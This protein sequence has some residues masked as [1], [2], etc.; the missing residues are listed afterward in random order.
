MVI[1]KYPAETGFGSDSSEQSEEVSVNRD[2]KAHV[3][4]QLHEKAC[5]AK[6]ALVSDFRGLKVENMEELRNILREIGVDFH[7]VKNTL[8]RQ[9]LEESPHTI[10]KESFRD[11]CAVAFGYDDPIVAAKTLV[12]Y[13]KKQQK[14]EIRFGSFEGQFL[15]AEQITDLSK[16]PNREELLAKF[17]QT[18]NA[19]PTNFVAVFANLLRNMLYAL[20]GIKQQ[21]ETVV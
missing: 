17:L 19:V 7:V 11:C 18:C 13:A 9:A 20:Q 10:I 15:T 8:V 12:D 14:F 1:L 5:Q 4:E 3:I 2:E 6:I 21:K 16:L